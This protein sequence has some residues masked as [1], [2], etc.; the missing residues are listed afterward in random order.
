MAPADRCDEGLCVSTRPVIAV[1]TNEMHSCALESVGRLHCFGANNAGALGAPGVTET[2][3]P[4]TV[5]G[6]D[7]IGVSAGGAFEQVTCG[8]RRDA[9]LHCWG[10]NGNGQLGTG[11]ET[12]HDVPAPVA[13]GGL[14]LDVAAATAA[15]CGIQQDG[16][17]WC[18]GYNGGGRAGGTAHP[19]QTMAPVRVGPRA[20]F[21]EVTMGTSHGCALTVED[22]LFCW[23]ED[24]AGQRGNDVDDVPAPVGPGTSWRDASAGTTHTCGVQ[25]DGSLWCWGSNAAGELG[26]APDGGSTE[27]ARVGTA[28]GWARVAAGGAFT[29]ALRDDGSAWCFGD[30]AEGQ[31]ADG[32][33]LARAE[34]APVM[35]DLRFTAI[36][37]GR[38]HVCAAG[39]DG[40]LYCWG[41]GSTSMNGTERRDLLFPEPVPLP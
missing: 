10:N 18:W 33:L 21:R 9:T 35:T 20:D 39:E 29:C 38:A 22:A 16:T 28:L 3:A 36:D 32:T 17:L 11:D 34:P 13:G 40:V 1:A 5:P 15:T 30:N 7:W 19:G 24:D 2:S 8:I 23:G 26:R 25:T 12:W 27:P 41:D 37:A 14:W 4:V 31:L 6:E